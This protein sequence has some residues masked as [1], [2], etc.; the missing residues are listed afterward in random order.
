MEKT[1][2]WGGRERSKR[3]QGQ[4]AEEEDGERKKV[5]KRTLNRLRK[6]GREERLK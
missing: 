3:M 5:H 4:K 1:D 6:W 2:S